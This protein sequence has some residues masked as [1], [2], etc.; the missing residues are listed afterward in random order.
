MNFFSQ[1][2]ITDLIHK[3]ELSYK[4]NLLYQINYIIHNKKMTCKINLYHFQNKKAHQ[5]VENQMLGRN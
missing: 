4:L 2:M 3:I 1:I 5:I